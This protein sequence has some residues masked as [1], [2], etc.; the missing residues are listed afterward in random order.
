MSYDPSTS[1][2]SLTAAAG[3][4]AVSTMAGMLTAVVLNPGSAASSVTVYD[5]ATT[6]A[7]TVLWAFVGAANGTSIASEFSCPIACSKGITAVVAG[8]G[9]TAVLSYTQSG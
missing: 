4:T 7:G 3:T 1:S 5:N 8:T 6:G 9:A 2:G